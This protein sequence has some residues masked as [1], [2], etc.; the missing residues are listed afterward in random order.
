MWTEIFPDQLRRARGQVDASSGG[1]VQVMRRPIAHQTPDQRRRNRLYL[2]ALR[3]WLAQPE[4]RL[5]QVWKRSAAFRFECRE[6]YPRYCWPD[7]Q[8][9]TQC[10]HKR[11]RR[12]TREGDLLLA[13]EWW[14]PVSAA[15]HD[16][17]DRN[18]DE[19]RRLGLLCEAGEYDTWPKKGT[20]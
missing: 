6:N 16:W 11:G 14:T 2:R 15:G 5:C 18:R 17:I 3:P 10:H 7:L 1:A 12:K 19:A 13:Q 4:N 9:A 8:L 20:K